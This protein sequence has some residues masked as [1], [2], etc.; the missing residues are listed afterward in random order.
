MHTL[1]ANTIHDSEFV[2]YIW[3]WEGET[4]G[5]DSFFVRA[6]RHGKLVHENKEQ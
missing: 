1:K 3:Q 6:K 2:N 4:S 5:I